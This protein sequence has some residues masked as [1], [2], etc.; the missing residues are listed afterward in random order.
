MSVIYH[1]INNM[2]KLG[3]SKR[4]LASSYWQFDCV[5]FRIKINKLYDDI[6]F[7]LK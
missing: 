1:E 4:K 2:D 5:D 6:D 3:I 7:L